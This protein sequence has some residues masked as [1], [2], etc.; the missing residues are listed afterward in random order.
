[1]LE[2]VKEG[3]KTYTNLIKY[4]K[5]ATS[6]NFGE[7]VSVIIASIFLP[8]LPET[9]IQLLVEGLIY[10]FG[11]LTL[12]FDNVANE[13]LNKPRNW[14][15]NDLK[16]FML[17]MGPLSSAFDIFVFALM[18]FGF[19]L[20]ANNIPLF[21]T[22]WFTYSIVSNLI[23]MHVIRTNKKP[24]L[25]S[26]ASKP[27]YISSIAISLVAIFVPYTIL[28]KAIGLVPIGAKY[29]VIFIMLIPLLYCFVAQIIKKVYILEHEEW[30]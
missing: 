30:L 19:N 14:D 8:F 4:I 13:N 18:W 9:P 12:P 23:G 21:Q 3:R 6:F 25:E 29:I 2:G 15:T 1:M 11:Q 20:R 17:I 7:V 24:F 28:G 10:D 27:V 5:L 26:H 22:I 16:R